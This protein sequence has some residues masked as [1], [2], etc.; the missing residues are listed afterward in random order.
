MIGWKIKKNIE[1]IRVIIIFGLTLTYVLYEYGVKDG[2]LI[3]FQ[4]IG[5]LILLM[6]TCWI[7]WRIIAGTWSIENTTLK[8]MPNGGAYKFEKSKQNLFVFASKVIFISLA[9]AILIAAMIIISVKI[10]I[11]N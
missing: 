4:I 7:V 5:S 9:T 11:D 8:D 6:L 3:F 1:S 10:F 2:L